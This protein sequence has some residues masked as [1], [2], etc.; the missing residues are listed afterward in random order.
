M[1]S[2][3]IDSLDVGATP[4]KGSQNFVT[5]FIQDIF[6]KVIKAKRPDLAN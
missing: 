5:A 4:V 1:S 3:Y 2:D 6:N